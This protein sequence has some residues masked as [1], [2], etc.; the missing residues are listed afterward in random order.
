MEVRGA[1]TYFVRAADA[2]ATADVA[3]VHNAGYIDNAISNHPNAVVKSGAKKGQIRHTNPRSNRTMISPRSELDGD[4]ILPKQAFKD[5]VAAREA[6]IDRSL[7]KVEWQLVRT[8]MNSA[9]N[10]RPML[11]SFNRSKSD[12]TAAA[13]RA[14]DSEI[15]RS[16]S[17]G[18]FRSLGRRQAAVGRKLEALLSTFLED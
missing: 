8:L 9:Q 16:V 11:N 17:S 12:L 15:A 3:W 5:A 13:W 7:T 2:A 14:T 6:I 18:Y 1:H 10:L 4:H